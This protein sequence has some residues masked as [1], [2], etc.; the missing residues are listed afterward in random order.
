MTT[1]VLWHITFSNYN[2]KA[3]WALDY[4]GV[5][6][7]LRGAPLGMHPLY[8][9]RLGGG[10]T[11][12]LLQLDGEAIGDSTRIIAELERRHPDPPLYPDDP[13][14]R[15]RALE[16]EDFFDEH[17]GHEVRRVALTHAARNPDFAATAAIPRAGAVR[18]AAFK[19]AAIPMGAL[20]RRY[21]GVSNA[22]VERAWELLA[23]AVDRFRRELRPSGY[24]AGDG[25]SVADLTFAALVGSAVQPPGFPY[26]AREPE[27]R[28]IPELRSLLAEKGVLE[29]IEDVY[30]S[31]RGARVRP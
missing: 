3:R 8:A 29:W 26:P 21:Y 5:R 7:R 17:A 27:H 10:R 1:P 25:F 23:A 16:L 24:L 19:L 20:M 12:P 22:S 28:G 18:L 15:A 2:E 4:K 6:Y 30:A 14:E 31:H 13:A 9:W 11:F